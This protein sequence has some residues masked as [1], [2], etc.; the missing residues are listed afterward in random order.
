[1]RW[2]GAIVEAQR[3]TD[4]QLVWCEWSNT[5]STGYLQQEILRESRGNEQPHHFQEFQIEEALTAL[6]SRQSQVVSKPESLPWH[7]ACFSLVTNGPCIMMSC[8]E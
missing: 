1:M 6:L 2:E 8:Y 5:P 3:Q 4:Q 7:L